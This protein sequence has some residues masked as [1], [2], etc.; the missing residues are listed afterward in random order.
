MRKQ[1]PRFLLSPRRIA[2]WGG[3]RGRKGRGGAAGGGRVTAFACGETHALAVVAFPENE[4]SE[5]TTAAGYVARQNI[6]I[7]FSVAIFLH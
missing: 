3:G 4:V 5:R 1:V 7:L 6:Y 2:A